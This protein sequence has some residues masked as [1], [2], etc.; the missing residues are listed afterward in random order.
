MPTTQLLGQPSDYP[1][2]NNIASGNGTGIG[3]VSGGISSNSAA[4]SPTPTATGYFIA[5]DSHY[6]NPFIP[7]LPRFD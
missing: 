6:G 4:F 1:Q 5:Q 7:V 2:S 3:N